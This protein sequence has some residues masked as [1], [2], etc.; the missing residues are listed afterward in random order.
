[1]CRIQNIINAT[2]STNTSNYDYYYLS[3]ASVGYVVANFQTYSTESYIDRLI[4]VLHK[5]PRI[6]ALFGFA[7]P[8]DVLHS[9]SFVSAIK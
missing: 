6:V 7:I 9:A 4:Q 8:V 5:H 2:I 1:M 3:D